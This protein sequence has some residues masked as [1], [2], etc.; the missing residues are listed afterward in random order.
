MGS[1]NTLAPLCGDT[2]S[3][4]IEFMENPNVKAEGNHERSLEIGTC[5]DYSVRKYITSDW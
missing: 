5:N 4:P 2:Y 3:K 1:V